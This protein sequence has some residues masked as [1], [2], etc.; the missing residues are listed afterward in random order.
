MLNILN[1]KIIKEITL[2]ANNKHSTNNLSI[3]QHLPVIIKGLK[4][5]PLLNHTARA[6]MKILQ[7]PPPI[8]ML[9]TVFTNHLTSTMITNNPVLT[10]TTT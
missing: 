9:P 3:K 10:T 2:I 8:T 6:F 1:I 5:S 4:I 7:I